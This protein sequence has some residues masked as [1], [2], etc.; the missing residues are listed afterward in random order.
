[1]KRRS[2]S[3]TLL[4]VVAA[5]A[6]LSVSMVVLIRSQTEALQNVMRVRNYER[7]VFIC[8]NQLHWTLLDLREV[9][10]WEELSALSGEDGDYLWDVVIQPMDMEQEFDTRVVM[11]H[12]MATTT[13]PEGRGEGQV[14]LETCFLWGE[15]L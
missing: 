11:L 4:E 5:L 7:A 1:M 6:I 3:F 15:E 10:S 2:D 12:V 14:E 8:E 9:E 13:W